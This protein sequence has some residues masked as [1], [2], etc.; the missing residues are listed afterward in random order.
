LKFAATI[1]IFSNFQIQKIIVSA[2]TIREKVVGI[3]IPFCWE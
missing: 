3:V 2:E 1:G